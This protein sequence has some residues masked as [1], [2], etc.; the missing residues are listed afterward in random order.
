MR[1][2]SLSSCFPFPLHITLD[3]STLGKYTSTAV[4]SVLIQYTSTVVCF[5]AA[6]ACSPSRWSSKSRSH[7]PSSPPPS[8]GPPSSSPHSATSSK[9][10]H[11]P[12]RMTMGKTHAPFY[13]SRN[14]MTFLQK[15]SPQLPTSVDLLTLQAPRF[16]ITPGRLQHTFPSFRPQHSSL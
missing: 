12:P 1:F 14:D 11:E 3:S 7:S 16:S 2:P 13:S 15:S 6:A 4:C 8:A 9:R 10:H 5:L